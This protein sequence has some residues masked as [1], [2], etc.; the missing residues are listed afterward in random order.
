VGLGQIRE[1]TIRERA[2]L[3]ELQESRTTEDGHRRALILAKE[4]RKRQLH[5]SLQARVQ[6][7][8]EA[9]AEA[10]A[11]QARQSMRGL[12]EGADMGAAALAKV[13]TGLGLP[14]RFGRWWL[15][16]GEIGFL[17]GGV[18]CGNQAIMNEQRAMQYE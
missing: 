10:E 2:K 4:A 17:Q 8:A 12:A 14:A 9:E 15:N 3:Q 11:T 13:A 18:A 6:A 5:Q 16:L 1:E 7:A